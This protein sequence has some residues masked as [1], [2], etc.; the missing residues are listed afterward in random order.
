MDH[1]LLGLIMVCIVAGL[2]QLN[3]VSRNEGSGV[4]DTDFS[5][6]TTSP[7]SSARCTTD[8]APAVQATETET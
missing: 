1:T 5:R 2:A 7:A 4:G 6:R 3:K 8:H